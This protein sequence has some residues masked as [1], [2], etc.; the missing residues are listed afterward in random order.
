MLSERSLK[1]D[2]GDL[3][4]RP[5]LSKRV[6]IDATVGG[7]AVGMGRVASDAV[8]ADLLLEALVEGVRVSGTVSGVFAL[9]C[10]RCLA[11][12]ED[13]FD[14]PVDDIYTEPGVPAVEEGFVVA[15]E[16][17]DLEPG[18]RDAVLLAMPGNPLHD[19]GCKGLC[20]TCGQDLNTGDCGH[21]REPADVRWEPLRRLK[22]QI[23]D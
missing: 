13:A 6:E 11:A 12:F 1:L 14:A 4:R 2:V 9:E 15:D 7:L 20:P 23:G 21:A 19:P 16:W 22:D 17:I 18:L 5:G 8:H 10:S 3:L